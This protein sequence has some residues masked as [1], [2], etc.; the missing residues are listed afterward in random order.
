MTTSIDELKKLQTKI[1]LKEPF[2][3]IRFADAEYYIL[4]KQECITIDNWSTTASKTINEDLF[5]SYKKAEQLPNL[6][7]AI[8]CKD[9]LIYNV[10][11]SYFNS[12]FT[13]KN[14]TYGTLFINGQ[15]KHFINNLEAFYYIGSGTKKTNKLK[16]I[17]RFI[18]D[19]FLINDWDIKK[20]IVTNALDKWI[21]N[22]NGLF[23]FSTGSLAKIWIPY[24]HEK[25]PNNQYLD[26]GSA[27]EIHLKDRPYIRSFHM[28]NYI[29]EICSFEHG[30][31]ISST[32]NYIYNDI[33]CILNLYKRPHTLHNQIDALRK[34]TIKP[35]KIIVWINN[36]EKIPII[37]DDITV[38]HSN[39]N[40]GVWGR[41]TPALLANTP[42]VC[43][44]DDDTIPGSKWLENCCQ[45][46]NKVNGLLGTVGVIFKNSMDEYEAACRHGW[47]DGNEEI[48]QVDIVGHSWFFKREWVQYM[49]E[50]YDKETMFISGEDIALSCALQKKGINTY[51]PPH[52][53]NDIEMF[54][55]NPKLAIELGIDE[56][57]AISCQ[58]DSAERFNKTFEIFRKKYGFKI[59]NDI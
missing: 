45:T 9:C 56:N 8:P 34:Q 59:L 32:V 49:W 50:Y 38:I 37:P 17:D 43:I 48:K 55:S 25:Y 10:I 18:I 5:K 36:A 2:S 21:K 41:F 16:V 3:I 20:D 53:I 6:Y 7:I 40:F 47:C 51:V 44:F 23:L 54:G 29:P 52:P 19:E 31:S 1:K 42:Y 12:T 4:T 39:E 58:S 33:T 24:F 22:K 46:M 30:H 15:W 26:V 11:N 57:V 28:D 13:F 27:L 14:I 35:K